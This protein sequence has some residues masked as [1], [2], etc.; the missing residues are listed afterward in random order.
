MSIDFE[1]LQV[2]LSVARVL[3]RCGLR[4]VVGGSRWAG[5]EVTSAGDLLT[6][7]SASSSEERMGGGKAPYCAAIVRRDSV[8]VL[9]SPGSGPCLGRRGRD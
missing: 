6:S 5:D 7:D 4:Y 1:P 8:A 9:D 3:E 2:A